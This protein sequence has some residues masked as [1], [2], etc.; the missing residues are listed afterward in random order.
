MG[1]KH[2]VF[3]MFMWSSSLCGISF[4]TMPSFPVVE[5][6]FTPHS[7]EWRLVRTGQV[8]FVVAWRK[9][10]RFCFVYHLCR[11]CSNVLLFANIL[12]LHAYTIQMLTQKY[13]QNIQDEKKK[14]GS[15]QTINFSNVRNLTAAKFCLYQRDFY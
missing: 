4:K 8:S 3:G 15:D 14:R 12:G 1:I 2:S 13:E 9:K 5:F 11:C 7:T 10:K 6:L